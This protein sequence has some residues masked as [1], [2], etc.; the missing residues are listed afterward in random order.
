ML[1]EH[2]TAPEN[3][4]PHFP[5]SSHELSLLSRPNTVEPLHFISKSTQSFIVGL[6]KL[7]QC[8]DKETKNNQMQ[9]KDP[10]LCPIANSPIFHNLFYFDFLRTVKGFRESQNDRVEPWKPWKPLAIPAASDEQE[11]PHMARKNV[12]NSLKAHQIWGIFFFFHHVLGSHNAQFFS[13]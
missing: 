2:S 11:H 3:L 13:H 1:R 7:R 6:S 9:V 8:S 10:F 12:L 5:R 4:S